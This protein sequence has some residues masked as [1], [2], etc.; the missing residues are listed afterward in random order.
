M[1]LDVRPEDP[2]EC[3]FE[4]I[5]CVLGLAPLHP[6]VAA[7]DIKRVAKRESSVR[8]MLDHKRPFRTRVELVLGVIHLLF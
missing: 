2:I 3:V 6:F 8:C 5:A 1:L 7:L 4:G